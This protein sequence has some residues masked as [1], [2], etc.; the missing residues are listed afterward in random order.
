MSYDLAVRE[1]ER[2]ADDKI[3]GQV[4][5][6]PYDRYTDSEEEEPPSERIAAYVAVLLS[7]GATSPRKT[8]TLRPGRPGR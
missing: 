4:F 5:S 7:G 1:G 3:A 8:R 6:D 2:P